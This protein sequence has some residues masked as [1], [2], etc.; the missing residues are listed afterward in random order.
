MS[1]REDLAVP[2]VRNLAVVTQL[3]LPGTAGRLAQQIRDLEAAAPVFA[4]AGLV[5]KLKRPVPLDVRAAGIATETPPAERIMGGFL[6]AAGAVHLDVIVEDNRVA[7]GMSNSVCEVDDIDFEDQRD[8]LKLIGIRQAYELADAAMMDGERRD[9]VIL[10]CPLLLSRAL[11]ASKHD[12]AHGGHREAYDAAFRAIEAFWARHRD[13]VFP[14]AADGVFVVGVGSGRYGAVL[15]LADQ[16]L[17][18]EGGRH[19]VAPGEEIDRAAL[20]R[21]E[22]LQQSVLAIG[23]RR[24]LQGLLGPFSRTAAYHLNI[25]SPRMEPAAL[26]NEGVVG[27]HFK[28]V[29]GTSVRFA[30]MLG[31]PEAWTAK[32]ADRLASLLTAMSAVGGREAEPLPVLL[33]RRELAP[34]GSFLKHYALQVRGHLRARKNENAWLDGLDELD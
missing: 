30:H 34:L 1:E 11:A 17:R 12:A 20:A 10:D 18:T 23:E 6:Y 16:D 33:A 8:R 13:R 26:T 28:G 24:F 5:R 15:Q 7:T 2:L 25:Q 31:R 14:W 29:E 9:L 4:D 3:H 27:F 32:A 21:V 22:R 19:F